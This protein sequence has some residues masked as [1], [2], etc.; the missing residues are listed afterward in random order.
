MRIGRDEMFMEMARLVSLRS[1]C[2]RAQVGALIVRDH[3]VV[4]MGYNGAPSGLPHCT[5]VGCYHEEGYRAKSGC[6]RSIHAEANAIAFAAKSGI[7]TEGATLYCTLSPCVTCA[8]LIINA[9]IK[10]VAYGTAYR[11]PSGIILLRIA[12]LEVWQHESPRT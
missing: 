6:E 9:G 1:T 3:R 4:S 12:G 10:E 8:N 7:P 11:D 5:D 2:P